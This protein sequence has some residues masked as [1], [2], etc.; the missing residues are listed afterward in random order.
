MGASG[1][2]YLFERFPS[3]TQTFCVR[4]VTALRELGLRFPVFSLLP[5][6]DESI[7]N[8]SGDLRLQTTA[9]PD[10]TTLS[11]K[12]WL[13]VS[14]RA[15]G[16]KKQIYSRWG[17]EGGRMRA[18]EAA[19]IGPHLRKADVQHVHVHFAGRAART[20][21]WLKQVY[22]IRYSFTAHANDFF[23]DKPGL[24]LEDL[25]RE[26]EFVVT[27]SDFSQQQLAEQYPFAA[28]KIHRV[29][30][31][32]DTSGF[33]AEAPTASPPHIVSVGR[34]IEKKGFDDLIQACSQLQ[35]LDFQCSIVGE[36]TEEERLQRM[37]REAGLERKVLLTGP[38]S[39]SE[40][41]KLLAGATLFTLACC[42]EEDGGMDNLPTVI[43]EAMA[44]GLPVIS[45]RLAGVPEMV[46][47]GLTGTL[48]E[49][50][51]PT[52]LAN[53]IRKQLA[54]WEQSRE[55]GRKGRSLAAAKFDSAVTSLE[56][57]ELFTRYGAVSPDS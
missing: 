31:G 15:R 49:P 30:N 56:I 26:A 20:A 35:D 44:A 7:Q 51:D 55:M 48:V 3:F 37:I 24:F 18:F 17:P 46:A 22:G 25:F 8:Y 45:T 16:I 11:R 47:E 19:W 29:Y 12:W 21:F 54:N 2:A 32:I 39:I 42:R 6:D 4:E 1:L 10:L 23:I 57:K 38:K 36:G 28:R 5:T 43:M 9:L 41:R 14:F 53:A 27:V 52:A 33:T 13:P 50:R 34:Y 40:I